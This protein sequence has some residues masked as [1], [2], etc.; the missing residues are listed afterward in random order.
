VSSPA[1]ARPRYE[2]YALF[3]DPEQT[4]RLGVE[5]LGL[6]ERGIDPLF[7]SDLDEAH[8]LSLQESGRVGALVVPGSLPLDRMDVLLDRVSPQLWA[9]P[10]AVVVV[11]PPTDRADLRALRDRGIRW[12]LHEPYDAAELRFAVAAAL[13][14]E[15]KLD[16][17]GGLRVPIS[18]P[19]A[20][21]ENDQA[22]EGMVR[23]LSIGGAYVALETP[24]APG[25]ILDLRLPIG[26]RELEA[27]ACVVYCQAPGASG[28]AV[29]EAGMGMSFRRLADEQQAALGHFIEERVGSFRL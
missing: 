10:Q 25:T 26:E 6:V 29:G 14:T 15:D 2:R 19:V 8:L 4:S 20:V 11:G 21:R 3:F 9:G 12:A 24:A 22:R 27:Q 18:L 13:A 23:N 17:R 16:P 5:A 1:E 28:R 7:A